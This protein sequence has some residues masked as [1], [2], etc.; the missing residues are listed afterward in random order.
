MRR[1][2]RTLIAL[3][4]ISLVAACAGKK[5][6]NEPI[7]SGTLE[8]S[9]VEATAVV[10][11]VDLDKRTVTIRRPDEKRITLPVDEQVKNLPQVDP[12]DEVVVAYYE[13]IAFDVLSADSDAKPGVTTSSDLGTAKEGD[14]PA[15]AEARVVTIT[16]TIEAIDRGAPSVTLRGPDGGSHTIRVRDR[17][18]LD[19][20]EIGE[21]V[22]IHYTQA[23]AVSVR[24]TGTTTQSR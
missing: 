11:K 18:K 24:E 22:E 20:L 7:L 5:D 4:C 9:L 10:E 19:D 15:A 8:E 14:K 23:V 21:L 2:V 16:S 1:S 12:G 3:A 17:K 13:S 6:P